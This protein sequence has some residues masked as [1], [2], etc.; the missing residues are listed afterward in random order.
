MKIIFERRKK[1][2]NVILSCPKSRI[3][4]ISISAICEYILDTWRMF[5]TSEIGFFQ[6]NRLKIRVY[7]ITPLCLVDA[8]ILNL[9]CHWYRATE[10]AV[11]RL[12]YMMRCWGG[13]TLEGMRMRIRL[14]LMRREGKKKSSTNK[15]WSTSFF[16][17]IV[18][19][20]SILFLALYIYIEI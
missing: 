18:F 1:F 15:L 7:I 19:Q 20:S 10:C 3:L 11:L 13:A 4:W 6:K 9:K 8:A 5:E 12:L 2:E 16:Q 14:R 17:N